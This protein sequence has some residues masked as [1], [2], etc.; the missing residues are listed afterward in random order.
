MDHEFPRPKYEPTER[1]GKCEIVSL[2]RPMNPSADR[3]WAMGAPLF[4][5]GAWAAWTRLRGQG[6]GQRINSS[7]SY[8]GGLNFT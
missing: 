1:E 5:I 8:S 6:E 4:G 7:V 2:G 3:I